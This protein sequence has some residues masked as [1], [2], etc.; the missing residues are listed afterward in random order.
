MTQRSFIKRALWK[1][2]STS[3]AMLLKFHESLISFSLAE[4][5]MVLKVSHN[6]SSFSQVCTNCQF[7]IY[8]TLYQ[9]LILN[10][11]RFL[12]YLPE[13]CHF[14]DQSAEQH[15]VVASWEIK[16]TQSRWNSHVMSSLFK[17][18][19]TFFVVENLSQKIWSF[20]QKI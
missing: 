15:H 9:L 6:S 18:S 5:S 19:V 4:L 8:N 17:Y 2:E 1:F 11:L 13:W 14:I 12:L 7:S 3:C 16:E 10:I 20:K